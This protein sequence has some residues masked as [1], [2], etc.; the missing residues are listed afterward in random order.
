[1]N[2]LIPLLL[3]TFVFASSPVF[4]GGRGPAQ[5]QSNS[6]G[7]SRSGRGDYKGC[8]TCQIPWLE[9]SFGTTSLT[10]TLDNTH[11]A[12]PPGYKVSAHQQFGPFHFGVSV[13]GAVQN[14]Q[15]E[16]GTTSQ[17]NIAESLTMETISAGFILGQFLILDAGYG[18]AQMR[19][20]ESHPYTTPSSTTNTWASGTGYMFGG[21]VIPLRTK[22]V[23]LG[24]SYYYFEAKS[25]G[26]DQDSVTGS[27]HTKTAAPAKIKSNGSLSAFTLLFN[28]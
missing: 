18:Y 6:E 23:S 21:S 27:T 9:L 16:G 8:K 17:V 7:S 2:R 25:T 10:Q 15:Q 12:H 4:A 14:E 19:R 24:V 20:S 5:A 26:Y 3:F 11:T 28:F 1:M 22:A 13:L